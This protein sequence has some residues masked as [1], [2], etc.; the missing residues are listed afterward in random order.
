MRI[1]DAAFKIKAAGEDDG[2]EPGQFTA[3]A[4][5]FGN[6]ARLRRHRRPGRVR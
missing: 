3:Y 2:L 6:I 1:K 5:V 4:S